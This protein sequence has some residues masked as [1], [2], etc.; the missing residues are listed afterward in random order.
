MKA[1]GLAVIPRIA[2]LATILTVF[3]TGTLGQTGSSA[4]WSAALNP[5]MFLKTETIEKNAPQ[6]ILLIGENHASVKTQDQIRQLLERLY[7]DG[8]IDVILIEGS[9]GPVISRDLVR[10]LQKLGSRGTTE[11]WR[12]Q[13]ESG[14]IA[15]YE[16]VALT[17]PG[18]IK[19]FGVENMEAKR[20][21]VAGATY[22]GTVDGLQKLSD[23][24]N[25]AI[26][27]AEQLIAGVNPENAIRTNIQAQITAYR[28]KI[29]ELNT[30][31]Q[32][33]GEQY[34]RAEET[35]ADSLEHL[36]IIYRKLDPI[37]AVMTSPGITKKSRDEVENDLE[38]ASRRAGYA[39]PE[40]ALKDLEQV[41]TLSA[42]VP[43]S[44]REIERFQEIFRPVE[45]ELEN[46]F[47]I[48]ANAVRAANGN[49]L[50][51][52]QTFQRDEIER[53]RSDKN[54]PEIPYLAERDRYIVQNTIEYLAKHPEARRV[55]LI[56]GTAHLPNM[57]NLFRNE[58]VNVLAGKP[59]AAS[60]EIEEWEGRA[61][62]AR[63]GSAQRIFS[64]GSTKDPTRLQDKIFKQEMPALLA[65]LR[66]AGVGGNNGIAFGKT[67]VFEVRPG[68]GNT[69]SIVVISD[70]N[71]LHADWGS[72]VV[73]L[74]RLPDDSGSHYLI[75]DRNVARLVAGKTTTDTEW[76]VPVYPTRTAQGAM[77]KFA[78]PTG[79]EVDLTGFL[80]RLPS[81]NQQVPS[82]IVLAAEGDAKPIHT[83]L[84]GDGSGPPPWT[85]PTAR[86][87]EPPER[88]GPLVFFTKNIERARK[89]L[90]I[91]N[92]SEPLRTDQVTSFELGLFN[93]PQTSLDN[94]WFTPERGDHARVLLIAGENTA[95]FRKQLKAAAEAGLL[96][97]KQIA[98][99]TCFDAKETDALREMLLDS[100]A[101]MV[102][103]PEN[104][105]SPEAARK[106]RSYMERVDAA[107]DRP[108][109]KALDD[110][111]DRAL[112]MWYREAPADTDLDQ[113]LNGSRWVELHVLPFRDVDPA[114]RGPQAD[115]TAI[116][117]GL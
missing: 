70:L 43:A 59:P 113:L 76:F 22:R 46:Q 23:F 9:Y 110:Y 102:W 20:R 12:G 73:G 99:A 29:E 90:D 79:T 71:N 69:K 87:A 86:F 101:T 5:E 54:D 98:L 16:Y 3:A 81:K 74:G 49:Q 85:T 93:A 95:E 40:A 60:E 18:E 17:Q 72:Y 84:G 96:K 91:V 115:G 61:W 83:A 25:R 51:S 65:R 92:K 67:R 117:N 107:S 112:E 41:K 6:S 10:N 80:G 11:F 48:L 13:L 56:I 32:K 2:I 82:R 109:A 88:R 105:I 52:L 114:T 50:S 77:T 14:Q 15:G 100:G 108:P 34:A 38:A 27:L 7:H 58:R 47:F 35:F 36:K 75:F 103:T 53:S 104:R 68:T 19:V 42:S 45:H 26:A 21:Y 44:Q 66:S 31:R 33:H 30:L 57:T 106:L 62:E 111:L 63:N 78:L 116:V 8:E 4:N 89:H 24:H 39:S 55:A 28:S 97:N 94:L 64:K 1:H 37:S